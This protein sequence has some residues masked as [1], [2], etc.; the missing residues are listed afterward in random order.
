MAIQSD[1]DHQRGAEWNGY[2]SIPLKVDDSIL[3]GW[4]RIKRYAQQLGAIYLED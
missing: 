4:S 2:S 3:V 1:R